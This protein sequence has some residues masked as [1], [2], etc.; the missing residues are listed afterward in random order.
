MRAIIPIP[1]L[2]LLAL[3]L[4]AGLHD[5]AGVLGGG[6]APYFRWMFP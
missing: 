3:L 4:L 1:I 5:V 2:A 6:V